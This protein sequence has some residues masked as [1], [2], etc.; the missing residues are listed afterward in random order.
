MSKRSQS[1][2]AGLALVRFLAGCT[3]FGRGW[4]WIHEGGLD[5]RLVLEN[6]RAALLEMNGFL[7]W[8][9][10]S[11]VL[12]NPDASA[13]IW[14]WSALLIGSC[15]MLGAFTRPAGFIACFFLLQGYAF[16]PES[17]AIV[18]WLLIIPCLGCA[19]GAAGRDFGL[20]KLL[21]ESCPSWMTWTTRK[22]RGNLFS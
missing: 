3:L 11:V 15:L 18:F 14:R 17:M 13:L 19:I 6:T 10:E 1:S 16:G 2:A 9:G 5:G 8:W 7:H 12:S 21:D 20:D 22:K 4:N